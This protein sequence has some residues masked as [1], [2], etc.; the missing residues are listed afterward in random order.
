MCKSPPPLNSPDEQNVRDGDF[1][2][3]DRAL[4]LLAKILV[5]TSEETGPESVVPPESKTGR[6]GNIGPGHSRW[7]KT[8]RKND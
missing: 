7:K 1:Y 8:N 3:S 6:K 4:E 2:L 5:D